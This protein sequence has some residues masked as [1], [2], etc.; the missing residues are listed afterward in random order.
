MYTEIMR[1]IQAGMALDR[2]KVI[3]YA[4]VLSEN[5]RRKG[6][7]GF[8]DRIRNLLN[9]C[10]GS[11]ATLDSL[12]TKPVDSESRLDIVDVTYPKT[13]SEDVVLDAR[14]RNEIDALI[15]CYAKRDELMRFGAESANSLLLYGPPGCGKTTVANLVAARA[16]LPLVTA[17][18]DALVSSLLGSTAKN[19]RKVFEYA[20]QRPCV[21]LLDEFDAVAKNRDDRN[22]L[23]ELKRVVNCLLQEMDDFS[24]ES[25][26]IA[27]T[28]HEELLDKAIWRRFS[29]VLRLDPPKGD[30][31]GQLLHLYL[32]GRTDDFLESG[33]DFRRIVGTMDGFSHADVRTVSLNALRG[34]VL[35]GRESVGMSDLI[36]E[37]YLFRNHSAADEDAF[38]AYLKEYGIPNRLMHS[39]FN[40]PLRK[41]RD[42]SKSMSASR[43][44][45]AKA[46]GGA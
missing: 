22:E 36:R 43:R 14:S 17:R 24:S 32:D 7:V 34:A 19:L 9:D 3:S 13:S 38:A 46:K 39:E 42:V 23:G 4:L 16:G 29:R 8:A 28:N 5:L 2:K 33:R 10:N 37:T 18:L 12:G 44:E 11:M 6:E 25:I 20:S 21:L 41:A 27:A 30:D 45:T 31:I 40:I 1:I 35:D 15:R 26:M